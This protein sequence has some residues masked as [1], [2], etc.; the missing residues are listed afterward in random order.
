[1]ASDGNAVRFTCNDFDDVT[2]AVLSLPPDGVL[3]STDLTFD[4]KLQCEC[5]KLPLGVFR[6]C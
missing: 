3:T 1:M 4:R 5:K 2:S 6:G